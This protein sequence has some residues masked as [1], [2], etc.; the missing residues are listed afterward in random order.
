MSKICSITGCGKSVRARGWCEMHHGRWRRHGDPLTL[1]QRPHGA[2]SISPSG[3]VRYRS[4]TSN[5]EGKR[6]H[7]VVA[8]RVL[9]RSLPDLSVVHHMNEMKSDNRPENL[10]ICPDEMYHNLLHKR[11]RARAACGNANFLKCKVCKQ[12]DARE[13]LYCEPSE[14]HH[15]HRECLN[16]KRRE[17]YRV[18]S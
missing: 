7:V 12:Y 5:P 15:W 8:E 17:K 1:K 14:R 13:N 3:Y 9:G 11:M 10:V 16:D 4:A 6:E 2:G 18:D